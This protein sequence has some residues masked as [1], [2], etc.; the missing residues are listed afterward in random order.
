MKTSQ[1]NKGGFTLVEMMLAVA[2]VSVLGSVAAPKVGEALRKTQEGS[3]RGQLGKLRA[4]IS[5]YYA[6]REGRFPTDNL[7]SLVPAHMEAIPALN[8]PVHHGELAGVV[9]ETTPTD[10]GRWSYNNVPGNTHWGTVRVGCTHPDTN[11]R[12]WAS[13]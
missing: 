13:L 5:I 7:T 9:T 12:A 2:V 3:T 8:I 6:D 11:G 1:S 10:T 4:A